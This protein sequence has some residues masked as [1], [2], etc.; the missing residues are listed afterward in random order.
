M[1]EEIEMRV[2]GEAG[3]P[4]LIYLSGVHG[5]W[6]LIGNLSRCL[7]GRVRLVSVIYQIIGW[8]DHNV[9]NMAANSSARQILAWMGTARVR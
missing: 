7:R 3:R 8:S 9:L 1:T 6:T 2:E 5:D 4:V